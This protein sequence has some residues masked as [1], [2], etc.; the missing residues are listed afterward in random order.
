M[1]PGFNGLDLIILF[2][3]ALLVFGPNVKDAFVAAHFKIET[4]L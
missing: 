4:V 2:V 1:I 3:V